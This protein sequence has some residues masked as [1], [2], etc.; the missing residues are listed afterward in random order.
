MTKLTEKQTAAA[1]QLNDRQLAFANLILT[2]S[3]HRM[4]N[5]ECYRQAGYNPGNIQA[6]ESNASLLISNHKVSAYLRVMREE[7]VRNTSVTLESLDGDL[8]DSLNVSITDVVSS[9]LVEG[10]HVL[11]LRCPVD[12]I[13]DH[14]ASNI[15]E[16]KQTAH[17]IQVKMYNRAD[18]RKL[19]YE[20]LGG[21]GKRVEVVDQ[22]TSAEVRAELEERLAEFLGKAPD[23]PVD[24]ALH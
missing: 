22:R 20:R 10:G 23:K 21:L 16:L 3:D 2:K 1:A 24:K 11:I 18:A 17:G 8:E 12:E 7:F 14:V 6:A 4:S 5:G 19:A 15:Q 9:E 13:P